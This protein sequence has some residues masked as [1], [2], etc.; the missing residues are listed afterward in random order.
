[1]IKEIIYRN[2]DGCLAIVEDN[3]NASVF[4]TSNLTAPQQASIATMKDF[5]ETKKTP[6]KTV[7]YNNVTNILSISDTSNSFVNLNIDTD[8]SP[9]ERGY[10]DAV[11]VICNE[12]LNS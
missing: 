12:L 2:E 11:G 5:C 3:D 6:L 8:L 9:T 4:L 10:L 1:M 7:T